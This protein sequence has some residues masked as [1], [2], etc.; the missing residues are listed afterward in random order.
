MGAQGMRS[1]GGTGRELG[2]GRRPRPG[3]Y[4]AR[5]KA[6]GRLIYAAAAALIGIA[7]ASSCGGKVA[8][9][10]NA[11]PTGPGPTEDANVSAPVDGG[12]IVF[13][14]TAPPPFDAS[15][16]P[17][18]ASVPPFDGAPPPPSDGGFD[19]GAFPVLHPG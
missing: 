17:F 18:D 9:V 14:A 19:C 16:P 7:A 12:I 4:V 6:M 2:E 8:V 10:S 15:L 3:M 13:D 5:A 11:G 1:R